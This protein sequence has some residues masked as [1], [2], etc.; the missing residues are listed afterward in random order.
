M[1]EVQE[2]SAQRFEGR[3]A[4]LAAMAAFSSAPSAATTNYWRWLA[5][6][7]A[8]K[9]ALM[10]HFVLHPPPNTDVLAFFVTARMAGRA[11]RT[12][13]LSAL[14]S[15]LGEYLDDGDVRC[16]TQGAFLESLQRAANKARSSDR[17]LLLVVDGL[18]EDA[19][20]VTASTGYSITALLPRTPP[21]GLRLIVASRTHPPLPG[22]VP[23]SHPLRDPA[24]SHELL[25]A[26]A[27]WAV[28]EDAERNLD[29]LIAAGGLGEELV[30]LTA[31]GGGLAAA[32]F[33]ELTGQSQRRIELVLGGSIGRAFQI[34]P[35]RYVTDSDGV[36]VSVYSFAHQELL[37]SARQL[38]S[39]SALE[40]YRD[41]LHAWV[42]RAREAGWPPETPEWALT[43]YPRTLVEL[44][45]VDRLIALATDSKRHERMWQITGADLDA[46]AEIADAF[47]VHGTRVRPDLS[48]CVRLAHQREY[49]VEKTR[50][51]PDG[52]IYVWARMGHLQRAAALAIHG[53]G[54]R[55]RL[56]FASDMIR[57]A[58]STPE[59][60]EAAAEIIKSL[61]PY[62]KPFALAYL[63]EALTD[64]GDAEKAAE[65]ASQARQWA[66][67]IPNASRRDEAA[68]ACA[69]LMAR[70]GREEEG[71][72]LAR[73]L[74]DEGMQG[75]ALGS[76]A[77]ELARVGKHSDA[78]N[79]AREAILRA[80]A[81]S[82]PDR[83]GYALCL[84]S[85]ALARAGRHDEAAD[86]ARQAVDLAANLE[87]DEAEWLYRGA[88][89]ALAQAG[90][91][92]GA[93][94]L[95]RTFDSDW[96]RVHALGAVAEELAQTGKLRE[97]AHF[98][99]EAERVIFVANNTED[100]QEA[101]I[102]VAGKALAIS[103]NVRRAYEI[104]RSLTSSSAIIA[105]ADALAGCSQCDEAVELA[106]HA[107]DVSAAMPDIYRRTKVLGQVS[108]LLAR[109]GRMQESSELAQYVA[110]IARTKTNPTNHAARL[111]E[112]SDALSSCGQVG[113]A[114]NL[115]EQ[116]VKV[117]DAIEDSMDRCEIL[118]RSALLLSRLGRGLEAT[119]IAKDVIHLAAANHK[120]VRLPSLLDAF[121]VLT[122]TEGFEE[123]A[124][125]IKTLIDP[126]QRAAIDLELSVRLIRRGRVEE[127]AGL[128]RAAARSVPEPSLPFT[129]IESHRRIARALAEAGQLNEA[130][131]F[132]EELREG[133]GYIELMSLAKH[134]KSIGC[135]DDAISCVRIAVSRA[136]ESSRSLRIIGA[137]YSEDQ[138]L[139]EAAE[140]LANFGDFYEAVDCAYAISSPRYRIAGLLAVAD[141]GVGADQVKR[142]INLIKTSTSLALDIDD[143]Y[144]KC[145]SLR[146]IVGTKA[147]CGLAEEAIILADKINDSCQRS[148]GISAVALALAE[149]GHAERAT[150]LAR[151]SI[152]LVSGVHDPVKRAKAIRDAC[153]V[154]ALTVAPKEVI[155]TALSIEV[156]DQRCEALVGI[157]KSLARS[158]K[159][160][161]AIDAVLLIPDDD[162]QVL[163]FSEVAKILIAKGRVSE[164]LHCAR[165][166]ADQFWL[167]STLPLAAES[168][169]GLPDGD[170]LL[171]EA[172]MVKSPTSLLSLISS[173]DIQAVKTFAGCLMSSMKPAAR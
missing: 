157:A 150:V 35:T 87:S 25:P 166:C 151:Q 70:S 18:D 76:V 115:A 41:R 123:V 169:R 86:I 89:M 134:L 165:K 109:C 68:M 27:A 131:T 57:A 147:R 34:R 119:G 105:I 50:N 69:N 104:G 20:L 26:P 129:A 83:A 46:L 111:V 139:V 128:A 71:A 120:S 118:A 77:E 112:V 48:A 127:A 60:L 56:N 156:H 143:E 135:A 121:E 9:T 91:A 162:E 99:Q 67:D 90:H 113:D 160:Q 85:R 7:W 149:M 16:P 61:D 81:F 152:D 108:A 164:L 144:V 136:R 96:E 163:T 11:D 3:E 42:E 54:S 98:A 59:A 82:G 133:N 13:F 33:A 44:Q 145:R 92:S 62:D 65:I 17:Q 137:T 94:D 63:G 138:T 168:L 140:F 58:G 51:A 15:Q 154:L 155:D 146:S 130:T 73:N 31:A 1:L 88:S 47:N 64:A 124:G 148:R 24:N 74:V 170:V 141:A 21:S 158:E 125:N 12:A 8:G 117:A 97:A 29:A 142:S 78:I 23:R 28:K 39:P 107:V 167:E 110:D 103:G 43:G 126:P 173:F 4:E 171:A 10:A 49:L 53:A 40:R 75:E 106:Q 22:D 122:E 116:A 66:L 45:D 153:Q 32:D 84:A 5:P 52:L 114:V 6:A 102:A 100:H 95:I 101:L 37:S 132:I 93:M 36:P 38:L 30:G 14:E 19:G 79:L 161:G 80:D 72:E 159:A 172:L 2:L 55:R